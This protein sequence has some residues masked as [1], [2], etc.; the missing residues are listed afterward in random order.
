M[1]RFS[2]YFL[3][4]G[5][6]GLLSQGCGPAGSSDMEM[7]VNKSLV[8]GVT[9]INSK[10]GLTGGFVDVDGD[11]TQDKV[12]GA[13]YATQSSNTG[14]VL[15]YK[16]DG[17]G[18][19]SSAPTT[20]MTGD[21]NFGFSFVKLDKGTN[22]AKEQFAVGAI[23]GDGTD[24]SLCGS[25]SI[26]KGGSSGP[27]LVAKL[28]GDGP[29]D[30]FGYALASGDFNGDGY[31]DLVVGAPFNTSSPALYQQGAVYVYF[32]PDFNPS[33]RVALYATSANG[34]L[35]WAV[36]TGNINNDAYSDLVITAGRKAMVY[37]GAATFIP[38][39]NSPNL[40]VDAYNAGD[41][42][43]DTFKALAVA[44]LD[45]DGKGEIVAGAYAATVNSTSNVGT[46]VIV[47]GT[48]TGTV[49]VGTAQVP[50]SPTALIARINGSNLFDRFGA[51]IVA[52]PDM[53]SDS[54][55]ELV[56]G[57]SSANGF[58]PNYLSG[59]VYLFKSAS[60]SGSVWT[61]SSVFNGTVKDQ[62][63]GTFLAS[64]GGTKLLIGAPRSNMDTGGVSMVDLATGQVLAGGSS[65][66]GGGDSGDCH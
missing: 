63:Y 61:A 22:D 57:A 14:A 17:S 7:P 12:V 36:A 32:G 5:M 29:M 45:G 56:I 34:G 52:V 23:H 62:S 27:Q 18:G 47:N 19:Y 16:G 51:S 41:K 66:G 59:R 3:L 4:L 55:Q 28:S 9:M 30:K 20:L 26:Y 33:T 49:T 54:K 24:V 2:S 43:S 60:R 8:K 53:D 40:T 6:V 48:A 1:K 31:T 46:V 42:T 44:D 15:V 35:G 65:G 64:A 39:L 37:Y 21:D 38:V 25:V 11:G 58:G 10:Q 50:A 13:P